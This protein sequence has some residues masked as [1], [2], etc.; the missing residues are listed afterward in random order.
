M[1]DHRKGFFFETSDDE[2]HRTYQ[3][4]F[5]SQEECDAFADWYDH[6]SKLALLANELNISIEK[7][8][9][10]KLLYMRREKFKEFFDHLCSYDKALNPLP[11]THPDGR[12]Q[13]F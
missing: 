9:R 10:L 12:V 13:M 7:H 2:C 6:V 1:K 11:V 3:S 4:I 5:S 8:N